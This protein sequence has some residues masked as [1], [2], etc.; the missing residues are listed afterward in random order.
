MSSLIDSNNGLRRIEL[1]VG[2]KRRRIRLGRMPRKQAEAFQVRIDELH[3]AFLLRSRNADAEQWCDRLDVKLRDKLVDIGLL[4]KRTVETLGGLVKRF[5]KARDH[6]KS[7]TNAADKQATDSLIEEFG[8]AKPLRSIT[9]LDA[10]E[11]RQGL[12]DDGLAAATIAKRVIKARSIFAQAV[13][14]GLIDSNPLSELRTGSQKN[15]SR[16]RFIDDATS[17]KVLEACPS[18]EWR[19]IFSLARWGGLRIPSEL[20]G[21]R[22]EDV[23][24]DQDRFRVRSP[25]TAHHP[26]GAERWVPLFP[27]VATALQAMFDQAEEGA[28]HV[29]GAHRRH[30]MNLRTNMQ[31]IIHKAGAS[32]WPRLFHNLRATRQTELAQSTPLYIVCRWLG[33]SPSVADGHYLSVPDKAFE[34]AARNAAQPADDKGRQA[35]QGENA[36]HTISAKNDKTP[37]EAGAVEIYQWAIQGSNL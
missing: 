30:A 6:V 24:W 28:V 7:S 25:K 19:A 5:F 18:A 10:Q 34:N 29:F 4:P 13:R 12:V 1:V 31:R 33:N 36:N 2:G 35:N 11:W 16:L 26:G 32:A 27:E 21:L 14:W 15:S 22:W 37:V 20:T 8:E 3:E 23:L 9:R 17:R